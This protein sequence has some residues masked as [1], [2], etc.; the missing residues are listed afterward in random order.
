M[1]NSK[2]YF[3]FVNGEPNLYIKESKEYIPINYSDIYDDLLAY[4]Q[5]TISEYS[6]RPTMIQIW[7]IL[8]DFFLADNYATY[9]NIKT[10][11]N[12]NSFES[13]FS[14]DITSFL[15]QHFKRGFSEEEKLLLKKYR[16]E[17]QKKYAKPDWFNK[18]VRYKQRKQ[19]Y[20]KRYTN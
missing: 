11:I 17:I 18:V 5:F 4:V 15:D 7:K 10:C 16:E 12:E 20:G 19:K 3:C 14:R 8:S 6:K 1:S 9:H 13:K 2:K